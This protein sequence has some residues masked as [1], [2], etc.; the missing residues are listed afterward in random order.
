MTRNESVLRIKGD[1]FQKPSYGA[2]SKPSYGASKPSYDSKGGLGFG[3][4]F[5]NIKIPVPD[6]PLPNPLEF[7][8][9][10]NRA[11]KGICGKGK[12]NTR[13][14]LQTFTVVVGHQGVVDFHGLFIA[15][16]PE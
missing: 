3:L 6:I 12:L 4:N 7:K 1:H 10:E 16:L 8:A 2:T 15:L 14:A 13:V 11:Q 9:G 5:K